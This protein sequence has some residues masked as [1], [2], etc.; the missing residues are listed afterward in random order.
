MLF[1]VPVASLAVILAGALTCSASAFRVNCCASTVVVI[2]ALVVST[3]SIPAAFFLQDACRSVNSR[4]HSLLSQG[5]TSNSSAG[6]YMAPT[7]IG[8]PD[9][10]SAVEELASA[11]FHNASLVDMFNVTGM[12]DLA[13]ASLAAL[14]P[15]PATR[16]E[17]LQLEML[18]NGTSKLTIATFGF[19]SSNIDQRLVRPFS[20]CPR[21]DALM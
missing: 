20:A 5:N 2:G 7:S 16:T 17:L 1:W 12:M 19:N 11:C 10:C 18:T 3:V 8:A 6:A 15:I 4:E 21:N 14:K 13:N 9:A